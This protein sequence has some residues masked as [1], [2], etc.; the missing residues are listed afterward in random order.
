MCHISLRYR[1]RRRKEGSGRTGAKEL[2][3]SVLR[4]REAWRWQRTQIL[5][6]PLGPRDSDTDGGLAVGA[7]CRSQASLKVSEEIG[8]FEGW[9]GKLVI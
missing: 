3:A 2:G 5:Q 8:W 9:L 7:L 1:T 6:H 4:V